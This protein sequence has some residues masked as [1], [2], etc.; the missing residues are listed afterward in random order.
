MI[1]LYQQGHQFY[2]EGLIKFSGVSSYIL[3]KQVN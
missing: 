2:I 1:P 3:N